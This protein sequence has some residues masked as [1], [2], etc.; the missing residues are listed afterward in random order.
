MK[1][2]NIMGVKNPIF[3]RGSHKKW[4]DR[5]SC[6]KKVELGQFADLMG[7]EGWQK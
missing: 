6:Q 5:V 4:I 1:N 7:A 3:R 2:F